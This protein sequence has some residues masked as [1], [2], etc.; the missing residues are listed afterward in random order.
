NT[1]PPAVALD[2]SRSS[3]IAAMLGGSLTNWKPVPLQQRGDGLL[4]S[5]T[6]PFEAMSIDDTGPAG[7]GNGK[8]SALFPATGSPPAPRCPPRL[9]S[10]H[11]PGLSCAGGWTDRCRA[12]AA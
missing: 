3:H 1:P 2:G 10:K 11:G 8:P 12:A 7:P 9:V 4:P 6:N 5:H